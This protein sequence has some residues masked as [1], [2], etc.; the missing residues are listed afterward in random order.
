MKQLKTADCMADKPVGPESCGETKACGCGPVELKAID[1]QDSDDVCCGARV[2]DKAGP[3]ER[4]GYRIWPFVET[5]ESTEA[6]PVPKVKTVLDWKD[7]AGAVRVRIGIGRENYGLAPGLYGVGKPDADSP[8]LVTANYKLTFDYLRKEL[9]GTGAWILVIDTR[10]IN[11]WCA[12]GKGTF[13]TEEVIERVKHAGLDRVVRHNTLILPQLSAT[14]VSARAVKKGC[15]FKVV[16]GPVRAADVK[17]FLENGMKA[18]GRMRRVTFTLSERLVLTPVEIS[19]LGNFTLLTLL[20]LFILSGI[21]PGVFSAS[22]AWTRGL[23][24]VFAYFSGVV[25]GTVA[26]PA[27]L[28]WIPGKAFSVKGALSGLVF[29]VVTAVICRT[30]INF[31]AALG[32]V[33]FTAA[34]SSFLAMN[35][36]GATPFT[37]PS[38]VEKEMRKALPIQIG[39]ALVCVPLWIASAFVY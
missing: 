37:S 29:G 30:E 26:T 10:G 14:G 9:C 3:F 20:I 12:A 35:F 36:T 1:C 8:V 13:S 7:I 25:S 5:F 32:I 6:G 34:I 22:S 16:W 19:Q 38:G 4:A 39:T 33:A 21:G 15:G 2:A 23:V 24:A 11:V 27:L 31:A 18:D 28:P 17:Q